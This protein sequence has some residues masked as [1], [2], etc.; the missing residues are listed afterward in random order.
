MPIEIDPTQVDSEQILILAKEMVLF[1]GPEKMS[2]LM[3]LQEKEMWL[4]ELK[5]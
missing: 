5:P 3:M 4:N 2:N 1:E